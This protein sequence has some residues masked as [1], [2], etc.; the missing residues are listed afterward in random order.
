M[1]MGMNDR[2][3]DP[4]IEEVSDMVI[5]YLSGMTISAMI[6]LGDHLGLYRAMREAGPVTSQQLASISRL[7]ERWVREWPA[8]K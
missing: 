7:H 1:M 4:K 5:G 6:Y 2:H 3:T 8:R